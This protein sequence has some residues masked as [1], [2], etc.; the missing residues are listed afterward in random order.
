MLGNKYGVPI[1]LT[2]ESMWKRGIK[3]ELR[4]WDEYFRTQGLQWPDEYSKRLNS[5]L[6]L[7]PT[8]ASLLP[9]QQE[10]HILDVGAGP[11]IYLGKTYDSRRISITA[12]D[13]LAIEYDKILQ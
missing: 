8:P 1:L 2:S 11:L 4:F 12:V 13:P 5:N 7:Q 3:S 10:V 6:Q 9:I